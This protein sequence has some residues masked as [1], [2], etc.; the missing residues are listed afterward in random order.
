MFDDALEMWTGGSLTQAQAAGALG[1]CER[2]FRRWVARHR[3][4]EEAGG[5]GIE[6]LKDRRLSGAAWMEAFRCGTARSCCSATPQTAAPLRGTWK[7]LSERCVSGAS[8]PDGAGSSC[9][10]QRHGQGDRRRVSA[11]SRRPCR[12]SSSRGPSPRS[13]SLA[14]RQGSR[15]AP[16]QVPL[17]ARHRAA[18]QAGNRLRH[19]RCESERESHPNT[20]R[21]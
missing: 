7:M 17:A 15:H 16:G 20:K 6:A 1:V 21:A 19:P 11:R 12:S 14:G 13:P 10:R 4:A 8:G 18:P 9:H 3:E 2:T 5:D